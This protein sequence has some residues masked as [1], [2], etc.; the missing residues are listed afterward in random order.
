MDDKET[1]TGKSLESQAKSIECGRITYE[2]F[3]S[4]C[5]AFL[6]I[7]NDIGDPWRID[8]DLETQG[9]WCLSVSYH[10]QYD[11][12]STNTDSCQVQLVSCRYDVVYSISHSV[13]VLYFLISDQ[14]GRSVN[15]E[16]LW[17]MYPL[18]DKTSMWEVVTQ[19][20]HPIL[21]TPFFFVHPCATWKILA[22]C[23]HGND[24]YSSVKYLITWLSFVGNSFGLKLSH[25]YLSQ[26]L[27]R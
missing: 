6:E 8:G 5:M 15:L 12:N 18:A 1:I 9:D 11:T 13:P 23:H 27:K 3:K 16:D 19:Q 4:A 20:E 26:I 10:R 21:A 24:D 17:K 2:A 25:K 7:A 22:D 14:S